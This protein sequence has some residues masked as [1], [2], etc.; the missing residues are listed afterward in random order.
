MRYDLYIIPAFITTRASFPINRI[1]LPFSVSQFPLAITISK[2]EFTDYLPVEVIG[3][4]LTKVIEWKEPG[5]VLVLSDNGSLP[6]GLVVRT[7]LVNC[8]VHG[9]LRKPDNMTDDDK[10]TWLMDIA[11][12][13]KKAIMDMDTLV[14]VNWSHIWLNSF[15]VKTHSHPF[16]FH[17]S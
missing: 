7:H 16:T 8:V 14:P 17:F 12:A 5:A 6:A 1:V 2:S 15:L 3:W 10:K 11:Q 4:Y 13:C 9:Q